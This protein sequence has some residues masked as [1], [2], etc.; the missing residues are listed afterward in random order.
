MGP[1]QKRVGPLSNLGNRG[2]ASLED[3]GFIDPWAK[4]R[5]I[6]WTFMENSHHYVPGVK[7]PESANAC[8]A[9]YSGG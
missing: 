3:K 2:A 4:P 1:G 5:G 9:C 6:F 7:S 8:P